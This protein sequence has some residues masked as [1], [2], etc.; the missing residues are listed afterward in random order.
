M[1]AEAPPQG[2][3]WDGV[4]DKLTWSRLVALRKVPPTHRMVAAFLGVDSQQKQKPQYMDFNAM[5][6]FMRRTGGRI[7][8]MR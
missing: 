5:A 7:D 4:L 2:G 8:G 1:R 6:D 3:D